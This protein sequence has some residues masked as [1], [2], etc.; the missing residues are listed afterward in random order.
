MALDRA[1]A[2]ARSRTAATVPPLDSM[3][4]VPKRP[5]GRYAT[6]LALIALLVVFTAVLISNALS[7]QEKDAGVVTAAA[8]Q[9]PLSLDIVDSSAQLITPEDTAARVAAVSELDVHID[10]LATVQLGLSEGSTSLG[11]PAD[12]P[13][14]VAELFATIEPHSTALMTT[15][16]EIRDI[17]ES[18][19]D[20]PAMM[21][22]ELGAEADVFET[23]MNSL[24]FSL[25]GAAEARVT[26]LRT[27]QYVLLSITLIVLVLEGLFLFRPAADQVKREGEQQAQRH[28]TARRDDLSYLARFDPLT[29]LINRFLFGDRLQ[30]AIARARREG[31]L[32]ALMFLDLDEFKAVNDRFGHA[33]GDVLLKQVSDRLLTSVRESDTVA[34]LGGDEFIVILEGVQRVEDAGHVATK[35]LKSL[36]VPYTLGHRILHVTASIGVAVYPVDD[37]DELLKDA[38]IAMYSAKAAGRN[39]YQFF[40]PELREQTSERLQVIDELRLALESGDQLELAYQPKVNAIEPSIIGVE[41]LARWNHP[42]LG[43]VP[44][45]RFVPLAE[46][47]DLIIPLGD[48]VLREAC[49]QMKEWHDAG[50]GDGSGGRLTVSVNVSSRQV[51]QGNLVETVAAALDETGL[52]A[53][54]LEIELTEGTLIDDTE[55]ARRTLER[56][57]TMGMRIAIDDF[58]TG[59]SSLSYLQRF[60]IDALKIDRTFVQDITANEDAAALSAAIIGLATSLRLDVIA[61]GVETTEQ[62]KVL[63]DLGCTTMQGFLFAR[64]LNPA[65]FRDFHDQG[66]NGLLDGL[67][68]PVPM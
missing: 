10:A 14:D 6:G 60:S 4:D 59:Y 8:G 50:V 32:V 3:D 39:T 9:I 19:A 1:E 57:R 63:M 53:R 29:G 56:L 51:R 54:Y 47:S 62:L 48:W 35:I 42:T 30:N 68:P 44:P 27:T 18:G 24:V 2:R 38:D 67:G 37:A 36:E 26:R 41:A 40:T 5:I 64:P 25:Q 45:S 66:L 16:R 21:V 49:R 20:V 15:A 61:E 31:G 58:G 11:L 23:G 7:R 13:K 28:R 34:R 33:T 65:G 43:R 12:H 17:A 46:E 52:E 55:L 22:D